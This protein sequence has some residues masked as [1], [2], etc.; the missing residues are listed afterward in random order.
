MIIKN[1]FSCFAYEGIDVIK[2]ILFVQESET[3]DELRTAVKEIEQ[4][5]REIHTI[6]Q[7]IHR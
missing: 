1:S 4:A 6:L 2:M 7:K 3:R 5:G